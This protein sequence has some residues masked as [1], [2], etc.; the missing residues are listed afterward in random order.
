MNFSEVSVVHETQNHRKKHKVDFRKYSHS[1]QYGLMNPH[2]LQI[3]VIL[4]L[5]CEEHMHLTQISPPKQL[6]K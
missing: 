2:F 5:T 3:L 6:K 1:V 4:K